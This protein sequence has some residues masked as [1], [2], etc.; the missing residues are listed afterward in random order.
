[1]LSI[2]V[3]TIS[4]SSQEYE[5][6]S[7]FTE[8]VVLVD[9]TSTG[10]PPNMSCRAASLKSTRLSSVMKPRKNGKL[11]MN[12][13]ES[14]ACGGNWALAGAKNASATITR[15]WRPKHS[16][17]R[18]TLCGDHGSSSRQKGARLVRRG[19]VACNTV[20]LVKVA[21]AAIHEP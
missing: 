1:M 21:P 14:V 20:H 7:S 19:V 12:S 4:V 9:T 10:A 18:G 6:T 17:M 3:C 8:S 13:C 15:G 5:V 11:M 2:A 16:L